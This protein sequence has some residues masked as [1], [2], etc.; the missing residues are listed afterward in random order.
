MS[1]KTSL[2]HL[3]ICAY[4]SV[5]GTF[6]CGPA[7]LAK[8]LEKKCMKYSDVNPRKTRFYFNKENFWAVAAS[9]QFNQKD[10]GFQRELI[11]CLDGCL[12][13]ELSNNLEAN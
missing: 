1:D 3:I 9:N 10:E 12:H 4:R 5:V 11:K 13:A 6:L 2:I 8:D 7:A